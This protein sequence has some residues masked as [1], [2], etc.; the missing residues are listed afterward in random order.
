MYRR[1]VINMYLYMYNLQHTDL[2]SV[3]SLKHTL[4]TSQS[5]VGLLLCNGSKN[6]LNLQMIIRNLSP[7]P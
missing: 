6:F 1:R 4:H 7:N 5:I 2:H 3:Q